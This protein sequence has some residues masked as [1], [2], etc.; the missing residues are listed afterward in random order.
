M[1][2]QQGSPNCTLSAAN[3]NTKGYY[4]FG[5]YAGPGYDLAT[6]LGSVDA[7][8]LFNDWNALSFKSTSTTLRLSRTSFT[9]GTAVTVNVGVTGS[10][11]TPSGGVALVTTATPQ[12]NEGLKLLTLQ[13]GTASGNVNSLPG[14][15]YK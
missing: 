6:G 13:S 8:Q 1:P 9:H 14:G 10:G 15:Q 11:G 12:N 2:C 3:D 4:A 5:Y 7:N